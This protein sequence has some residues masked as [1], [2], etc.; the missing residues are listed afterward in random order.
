MR[1][2]RSCTGNSEHCQHFGKMPY[3]Y[4][5]TRLG[6]LAAL[7]GTDKVLAKVAAQTQIQQGYNGRINDLTFAQS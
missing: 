4:I 7:N 2:A 3:T 5:N 6:D 1:V